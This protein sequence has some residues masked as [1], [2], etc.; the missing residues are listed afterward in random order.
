M[1]N[2]I[3]CLSI[4]ISIYASMLSVFEIGKQISD[5]EIDIC[6]LINLIYIIFSTYC[7]FNVLLK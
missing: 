3:L 1:L 2:L 5:G 4:A 7:M 6:E